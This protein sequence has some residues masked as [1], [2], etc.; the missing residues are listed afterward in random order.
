ML[1]DKDKSFLE[2][3]DS[4]AYQKL[5][6]TVDTALFRYVWQ[7][8]TPAKIEILL[9]KRHN[10][11][12]E[13]QWALPGGFC[14]ID[15][16]LKTAAKRELFEE[17]GLKA[18]YYGQ[19][20]TYG[21]VKRDPRM[22]VLGTSYLAVLPKS[23]A[24][25]LKADDDAKEAKWFEVTCH[26]MPVSNDEYHVKLTLKNEDVTLNATINLLKND[27][28][29]WERHLIESEGLAFDHAKMIALATETFRG[30]AWQSDLVFNFLD[31]TFELSDLQRIFETITRKELLRTTF[32]KHIKPLIRLVDG[33]AD[34][35]LEQKYR[36]NSEFRFQEASSMVELWQ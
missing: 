30:K 25:D 12:Y 10:S 3:Y 29:E 31:E 35:I 16:D 22:R 9:V 14:E 27:F 13:N 6:V 7:R 4:S 8:G 21:E 34:S 26:R 32:F 15:E 28:G 24:S 33:E 17:T 2:N 36:F 5:S 19:L 1:S 23:F 18:R 20:H 11:P